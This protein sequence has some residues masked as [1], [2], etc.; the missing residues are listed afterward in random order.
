M[1]LG[2]LGGTF[3]P[4]HVGH[5][6]LADVAI[7][8]LGLDKLLFVPAGDPWRK[9]GQ[10]LT[11]GEHRLEMTVLAVDSLPRM[12]VSTLELDRPGPSYTVDT[13]AELLARYGQDT[14]LYFVLGQ[15]ALFDMPNWKDPH[16]IIALA[17]LA[18]AL[19]SPGRD[20]EL[21]ELEK[22]IP[23]VSKRIAV[24]P[25]SFVDVSATA[26]REWARQG[27]SLGGLVPPAVE[28]YI[29]ERGLYSIKAK[30]GSGG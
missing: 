20:L 15:D 28:A 12:D 17:R 23:G 2:V 5:L 30:S 13:L 4:P 9:E 21:T 19:R 3:D 22:A 24:L 26:V 18:V 29:K 27:V 14:E 11:P 25:M 16:R 6:R 8:H 1:N 7:E 10:P